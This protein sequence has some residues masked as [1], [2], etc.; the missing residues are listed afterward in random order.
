MNVDMITS[1]G[2]DVNSLQNGIYILTLRD[3]LSKNVNS[4]KFVKS[5]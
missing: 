4:H 3:K 2:L 5:N 1:D